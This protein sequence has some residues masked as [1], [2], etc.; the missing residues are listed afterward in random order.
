MNVH[1]TSGNFSSSRINM[2]L[3][4][5]GGTL[6]HLERGCYVKQFCQ[7]PKQSDQLF[8]TPQIISC[9]VS[10]KKLGTKKMA[11]TV[12]CWK[13]YTP[14]NNNNNNN[15]N[16]AYPKFQSTDSTLETSK[17][18]TQNNFTTLKL[19]TPNKHISTPFP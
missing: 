15:N 18:Q 1:E 13:Y 4:E 11:W 9:P 12:T 5:L 2:I 19:Q 17:F 3:S 6:R 10:K 8:Q 14:N 7:T 16:F